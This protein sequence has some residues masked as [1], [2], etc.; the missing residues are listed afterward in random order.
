[1]CVPM[2]FT[3]LDFLLENFRRNPSPLKHC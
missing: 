3:Y 1:M 2:S